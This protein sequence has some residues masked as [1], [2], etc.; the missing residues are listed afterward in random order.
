MGFKGRVGP[1]STTYLYPHSRCRMGVG[2]PGF[3]RLPRPIQI[4]QILPRILRPTRTMTDDN[5]NDNPPTSNLIRRII[6]PFHVLILRLLQIQIPRLCSRWC[7]VRGR[8]GSRSGSGAAPPILKLF[9]IRLQNSK[10]NIQYPSPPNPPSL[11]LILRMVEN[12][13][14]S[15]AGHGFSTFSSARFESPST[16]APPNITPGRGLLLLRR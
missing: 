1:A 11:S 10:T 12:T 2:S 6:R 14:L 4:L 5:D 3:L 7:H 9:T 8:S 13:C 16:M 15:P